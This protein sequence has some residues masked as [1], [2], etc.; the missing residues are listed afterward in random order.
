MGEAK[1][2]PK[3]QR[4]IAITNLAV[5]LE[6]LRKLFRKRNGSTR[7]TNRIRAREHMVKIPTAIVQMLRKF[8]SGHMVGP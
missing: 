5:P 4:K 1:A 3:I 8:K 7:P 6:E 2:A